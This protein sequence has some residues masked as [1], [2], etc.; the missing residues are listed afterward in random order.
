MSVVFLT[1]TKK[2]AELHDSYMLASSISAWSEHQY[3]MAETSE[4]LLE[5]GP[6]SVHSVCIR[7]END[8]GKIVELYI[9]RK[10]SAS[11]RIIAAT[12]H[13]AVQIDFADVDP[14]TGRMIPNK[15]TRCFLFTNSYQ[16]SHRKPCYSL[17]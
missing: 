3:N 14:T 2:T 16:F 12:D 11:S 6:F 7:M 4:L 8:L 5:S 15:V 10:C 13:A 17:L 1:K 9:P